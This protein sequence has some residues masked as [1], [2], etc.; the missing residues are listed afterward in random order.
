MSATLLSVSTT[1]ITLPKGSSSLAVYWS[2]IQ[3][4][5]W[6]N[7]TMV[8]TD[9]DSNIKTKWQRRMIG[10]TGSPYIMVG[11]ENDSD[12][13]VTGFAVLM[14]EVDSSGSCSSD[15]SEVKVELTAE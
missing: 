12:K 14:A 9:S 3:T 1:P 7:A 2:C 5:N 15:P 13:K 10:S 6:V 4:S 11:F 8:S